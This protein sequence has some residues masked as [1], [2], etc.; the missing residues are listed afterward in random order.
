LFAQE[1]QAQ[2]RRVIRRYTKLDMNL[3]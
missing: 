1:V 3:E 2:T